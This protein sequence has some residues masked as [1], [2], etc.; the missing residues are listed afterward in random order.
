M[1]ATARVLDVLAA[2][3]LQTPTPAPDNASGALAI[4]IDGH[5]MP[6]V[7]LPPAT[8][9]AG[10]IF[11]PLGSSIAAG[12][13]AVTL[14]LPQSASSATAQL[15]ANL[16]RPWPTV[17]PQF[18]TINN[19]QLRLSV[20]FSTTTPIPGKSV[21]VTAHIERI[22]FR[23]YGML[24]AEI[25]LPPGADVDRAS[26]ESAVTASGYQLNHYEVLPDRVLVYLWPHAGGLTLHFKFT[27][28]YGIDALTA[29]SAVYDYYNP[30][31]R[32]DASPVRFKTR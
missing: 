28:R 18:S 25:G 5:P 3:A 7:A 26:L 8:L 29:P 14:T 6:S 17:T 32:F 23:G 22:G 24:I 13:H 31:A 15:V 2:I 30:D 1:Q 27:P 19:E 21:N 11:V 9:D 12:T 10:P 16:Y 20:N 4:E